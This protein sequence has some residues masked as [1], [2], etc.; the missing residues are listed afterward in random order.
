MAGEKPTAI[1]SSNYHQDHFGEIYE[2]KTAGGEL[3]HTGCM[4]LGE[5]RVTLALF[6]AHGLTVADWPEPVLAQLAL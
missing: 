2:I 1:A 4:A 3:A 6:S 5:E